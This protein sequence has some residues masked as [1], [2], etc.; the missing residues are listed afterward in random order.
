[1]LIWDISNPSQPITACSLFGKMHIH[2]CMYIRAVFVWKEVTQGAICQMPECPSSISF[3]CHHFHCTTILDLSL[4]T[5]FITYPWFISSEK[6][7]IFE[8]D[9][10][11]PNRF[12]PRTQLHPKSKY[13]S[14]HWIIIAFHE[15]L[16]M[17]IR[18]FSIFGMTYFALII[19]FD[20]LLRAFHKNEVDIIANRR[21]GKIYIIQ[22]IVK[23]W[24]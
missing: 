6:N 9:C 1:M 2:I 3:G 13:N 11:G 22:L 14:F 18:T 21:G 23:M 8:S 7:T 17:R 5:F 16:L 12:W 20:L 4:L 10:I 24:V 19:M 15:T